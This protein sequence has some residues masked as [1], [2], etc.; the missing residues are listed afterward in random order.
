MAS[1][2]WRQS[3]TVAEG[4]WEE[5]HRFSFLQAVHLLETLLPDRVS[6]AEG[7]DPRREVVRFRSEVRLDF[8][9]GDV[10]SITAPKNG[11]PAEMTVNVLGLAGSM[12]PLPAAVVEL[13]MERSYRKDGAL[14]DFLD[15]FNH[16][17]IS[18]LYRARKKYRPALDT[19]APDGGRVAT[20]LH[21]L[22]GLG[23]PHLANRMGVRDRTLLAYTGVLSE[24]V[25][26]AIGLQRLVEDC[27]DVRAEVVPFRGQWHR[28]EEDD[29]TRIGAGGQNQVLGRTAVL[30]RR[31]WDQAASFEI[32]L[33]PLTLAQFLSFLPN[34]RAFQPLVA[35]VRFYAREELGFTFRLALKAAEVPELRLGVAYG[36]F[37]GWTT[38]MKTKPATGDDTQVRLTGSR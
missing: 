32:K 21:A 34:G 28:I 16:R 15:I 6:P 8:P 33:G 11:E 37:L 19:N 22:L 31:V 30:G 3:R 14:R 35:A 27:F 2:G 23:T 26:P 20:V 13:I 9:P 25:R 10:E 17:L 12:G 5:G 29:T 18:L 24:T 38:W 4:L 7:V 1:Y 36:A